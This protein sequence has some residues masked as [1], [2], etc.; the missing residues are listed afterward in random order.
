MLTHCLFCEREL[1][2]AGPTGSLRHA[3]VAFDPWL[4]RLWQ[5]CSACTRW[6]PVPLEERW[7]ELEQY[8]RLARDEARLLLKTEH[9]SL[10]STRKGQLIR[11][12]EAPRVEFADWRY[13]SRL[14]SWPIRRR[15]L[16]EWFLGLLPER[17][18]GE[19]DPYTRVHRLPVRWSGA[20]F[21]EHGALLTAIYG[22]VPLA[23]ACPSCGYP[24]M[25]DPA[26][27]GD[28]RIVSESD[29]VRVVSRCALCDD[30]GAIPLH[31][32][33]PALRV[34]LAVVNRKRKD[35]TLVQ[36]AAERIDRRAGPDG[37][38]H[39]LSR[40]EL[41][42]A[43]LTPPS[44]LAIAISLDEQSE[45]EVLE[46]EWRAAEELAAISDSELTDV[47][48]FDRFRARILGLNY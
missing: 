31:L 33:R 44:L 28:I 39:A 41:R 2:A 6:N 35:V 21:V 38:L 45:A 24:M 16:L 26:A 43:T 19:T 17:Q 37:F 47:P 32:A 8:D 11:V 15:T 30:T 36:K 9:L 40:R 14:D 23:D 1:Q 3:R 48:G 13:S 34:G 10:L 25:V 22:V 18:V 4:G 46:A 27:F 12:G 7:E 20:A 5:V 29:G 42:L